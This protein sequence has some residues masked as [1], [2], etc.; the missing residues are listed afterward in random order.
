MINVIIVIADQPLHLKTESF[1]M[2]N[3][4]MIFSGIQSKNIETIAPGVKK[5]ANKSNIVAKNANN[6]KSPLL[7]KPAVTGTKICIDCRH[8][9]KP[10]SNGQKRCTNCFPGKKAEVK[11]GFKSCTV[12]GKD[13]QFTF[14]SEKK[15]AACK[16]KKAQP[17]QPATP[18]PSAPIDKKFIPVE[19]KIETI[20]K[21]PENLLDPMGLKQRS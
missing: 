14:N 15:C 12:C 21:V 8:E 18:A 1:K 16:D 13:F 17:K 10:T 6:K 9:Y 3:D 11:K 4:Q 2:E 7:N 20:K 19:K 5:V